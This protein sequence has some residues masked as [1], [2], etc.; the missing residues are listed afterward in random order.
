MNYFLNSKRPFKYVVFALLFAVA[1]NQSVYYFSRWIAGSWHH[2]DM[3]LPIDEWFPLVPWT[4][5][6]YFG[7]YL[8]WAI[9]Y[10]LC[11][12]REKEKS[13]PFFAADILAKAICL[14]LFLAVPTT[15]V[16]PEI[17][18]DGIWEESMRMLYASDAADNLFPSIHVTVSWLCFIGVRNRKD[19][20]LWYRVLSLIMA[21]AVCVSTLTTKQHVIVDVVAAIAIAEICCVVT[22]SQ[23][24]WRCYSAIEAFLMKPIVTITASHT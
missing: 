3:T 6:I 10:G 16:R 7:C 17:V 22:R 8:F 11:A 15:N 23:K 14:V 20:P 2:Y 13:H 12:M 24:V 4:T 18:G 9:N 19:I 1:W 5:V 21:L